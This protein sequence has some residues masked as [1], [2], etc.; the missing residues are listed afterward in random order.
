M[1]QVSALYQILE[2]QARLVQGLAI[3]SISLHILVFLAIVYGFYRE[4]LARIVSRVQLDSSLVEQRATYAELCIGIGLSGFIDQ[5]DGRDHVPG[6]QLA[7]V[8]VLTIP[9]AMD[10]I[11]AIKLVEDATYPL[12]RERRAT[13]MVEQP[14]DVQARLVTLVVIGL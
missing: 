11:G 9:V 7:L 2:C 10:T 5:A 8:F 13:R 3:E 6:A 1:L 14:R 4:V 12:L